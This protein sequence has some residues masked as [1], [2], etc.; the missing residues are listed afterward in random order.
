MVRKRRE[1]VRRVEKEVEK[2]TSFTEGGGKRLGH[3]EKET[4]EIGLYGERK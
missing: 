3:M 2:N 4:G 1:T